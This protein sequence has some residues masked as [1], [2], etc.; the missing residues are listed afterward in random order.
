MALPRQ[1]PDPLSIARIHDDSNAMFSGH[2]RSIRDFRF[3]R[4]PARIWPGTSAVHADESD[5]LPVSGSPTVTNASPV[6]SSSRTGR[7]RSAPLSDRVIQCGTAWHGGI[8]DGLT[9]LTTR[10]QMRTG[11]RALKGALG[12]VAEGR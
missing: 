4:V 3:A 12:A 10:V 11:A 6:P 8:S 1:L 2:A 9:P 5:R 7:G